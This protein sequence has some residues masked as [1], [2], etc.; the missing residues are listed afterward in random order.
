[1]SS[2]SDESERDLWKQWC[3]E[4]RALAEKSIQADLEGEG[5]SAHSSWQGIVS[6]LIDSNLFPSSELNFPLLDLPEA[7]VT[8]NV[9]LL[10]KDSHLTSNYIR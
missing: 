2:N 7:N 8:P 9:C 4:I 3:C 10:I 5:M 1:M 6:Y